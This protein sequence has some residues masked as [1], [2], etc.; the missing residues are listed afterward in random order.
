MHIKYYYLLIIGSSLGYSVIHSDP[1]SVIKIV[2]PIR[3][4]NLSGIV[5]PPSTAK[6]I[7]GDSIVL[8]PFFNSG[9][10]SLVF[11]RSGRGSQ[12]DIHF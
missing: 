2:S 6:A 5:I 4:P 8:S 11:R 10:Y 12:V 9:F 7:P 1:F 3:A